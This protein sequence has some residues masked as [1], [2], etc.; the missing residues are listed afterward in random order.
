MGSFILYSGKFWIRR[1]RDAWDSCSQ[2]KGVGFFV[3][4]VVWNLS[5][6]VARIWAGKNQLKC[7]FLVVKLTRYFGIL[8]GYGTNDFAYMNEWPVFMLFVAFRYYQQQ[9]QQ[10]S[11]EWIE[12]EPR[13]GSVKVT[14]WRQSKQGHDPASVDN[15][16]IKTGSQVIYLSN[17]SIINIDFNV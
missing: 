16:K 15:L 12:K 5:S 4:T 11:E 8:F 13:E 1:F 2:K 3:F 14:K 6:I 7:H 10:H 9:Q 17:T